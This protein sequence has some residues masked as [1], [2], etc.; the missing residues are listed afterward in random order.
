MGYG[1]SRD[2]LGGSEAHMRGGGGDDEGGDLF[3]NLFLPKVQLGQTS[4]E[5]VNTNLM[6]I[7][8]YFF[9]IN[10]RDQ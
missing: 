2:G 3:L 7:L 10:Y 4:Q 1:V 6:A 5:C 8:Q 9:R